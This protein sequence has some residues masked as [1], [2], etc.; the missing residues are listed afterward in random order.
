MS[1]KR[2]RESDETEYNLP[3]RFAYRKLNICRNGDNCKYGARCMFIHNNS[4]L[5]SNFLK[6]VFQVERIKEKKEK[7]EK[8]E[9]KYNK[10][11]LDAALSMCILRDSEGWY[12]LR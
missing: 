3:K 5:A 4:I 1:N 11:E 12:Q 10:N 7:T 2:Q 8:T 9:K 6:D